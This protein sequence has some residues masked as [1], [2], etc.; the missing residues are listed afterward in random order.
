[1]EQGQLVAMVT[2]YS[3][4]QATCPTSKWVES[5]DKLVME[6]EHHGSGGRGRG[7]T[8]N[9]QGL[10]C[11]VEQQESGTTLRGRKDTL[12]RDLGR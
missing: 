12:N 5:V 8:W 1:M 7:W 9:Q 6:I 3:P 11:Q 2:H 10:L 4:A